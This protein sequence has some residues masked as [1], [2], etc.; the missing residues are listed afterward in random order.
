MTTLCDCYK[1]G[2]VQC[3]GPCK[4]KRSS[5]P[6][7]DNP[8]PNPSE[9]G[10]AP[11]V[12]EVP[13]SSQQN[14]PHLSMTLC[15]NGEKCSF[16]VNNTPCY[17]CYRTPQKPD[18]SSEGPTPHDG[19]SSARPHKRANDHFKA[20]FR[21]AIDTFTQARQ[22]YS[23][24]GS[25]THPYHSFLKQFDQSQILV[26]LNNKRREMAEIESSNS[27]TSKQDWKNAQGEAL[28]IISELIMLTED[29]AP[30]QLKKMQA[31]S[32]A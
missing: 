9:S 32:L 6:L 29:Q 23:K 20:R 24:N 4:A 25:Y 12:K 19:S 14:W 22:E 2:K 3:N 15:P 16:K 17:N 7:L 26:R 21:A 5:Q 8:S 27:A 31:S 18:K 1:K 11:S 10:S 30:H 13:D 28:A